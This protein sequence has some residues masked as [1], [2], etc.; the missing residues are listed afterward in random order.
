MKVAKKQYNQRWTGTRLLDCKMISTL[1]PPAVKTTETSLLL[2]A[3]QGLRPQQS[4][5]ATRGLRPL[6]PHHFW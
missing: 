5:F 6:P 3:V 2:I 4:V 1:I